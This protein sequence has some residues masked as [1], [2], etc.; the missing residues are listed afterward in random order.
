M[1]I[2]S[3]LALVFLVVGCGDDKPPP[4]SPSQK[5]ACDTLDFCKISK[6]GLSCDS[7]TASA[8]AQCIN[9]TS[10]QG[11]LAGACVP[12]CPGMDFKP[13]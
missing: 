9:G 3:V 6:K 12:Q 13:N 10:C 11:L 7:D 1:R 5:V 8:C 2:A 4:P